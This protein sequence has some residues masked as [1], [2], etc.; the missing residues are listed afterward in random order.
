MAG[1]CALYSLGA[2]LISWLWLAGFFQYY[3]PLTYYL[4]AAYGWFFGEG[5]AVAGV[6]FVYVAAALLATTGMYLFMHRGWGPA[7]ALVSAGAYG[8]T[9]YLVYML[10]H[11]FGRAPETFALGLA[12][13]VFWAFDRLR[14]P[15]AGGIGLA[16]LLL[17]AHLLTHNLTGWFCLAL[18]VAWFVWEAW[19]GEPASAPARGRHLAAGGLSLA[20]ALGL[21]A[22]FW[23]PAIAE[24]AAVQYGEIAGRDFVDYRSQFVALGALLRPVIASDA[25]RLDTV[26]FK[27]GLP[28]WGLALLA[29]ATLGL[30]QAPRRAVLFWLLSAGG[31]LFFI[32]PLSRPVWDAFPA[33]ALVQFPWRLLGPLGFVLAVLAGAGAA[34]WSAWLEHWWPRH[35]S[36]VVGAL[37]VGGCLLAAQPMLHPLPW[38][39]FGPMNMQRLL[40]SEFDWQVGS[41]PTQEFMP[42]AVT[43]PPTAQASLSE[44]YQTGLVDKVNHGA[45]PEGAQVTVLDHG[46]LHDRFAVSSPVGFVLRV[47]TFDFPGWT[48]FVN[49]RRTDITPSQPEGW[50]TLAVPAGAAEVTLR[51]LDTPPRQWGTLLGGLAG[52]ACLALL[53]VETR[54]RGPTPASV[55]LPTKPRAHTPTLGLA[56]LFAAVGGLNILLPSPSTWYATAPAGPVPATRIHAVWQGNLALRGYDLSSLSAQP[57][58]TLSVTLYWQAAAPVSANLRVFVHVLGPDGRLWA[59]SDK[60]HPG[61]F[62]DLPTGRWPVGYAQT[63]EHQVTLAPDAPA[64]LYRVQ[65]GLWQD[66]TGARMHLLDTTGQA[67]SQEAILLTDTLAVQATP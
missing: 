37:A 22:S 5:G 43:V 45:L 23:L 32:L 56:A 47:Y 67:T 14:A 42:A 33:L 15:S 39:D 65:A 11:V 24:R 29:A 34:A 51:L 38:P 26:G 27:L 2:R 10:P 3:A 8:F 25:Y 4:G 46:P 57:G 53:A 35:G 30:A 50:I 54:R 6:K 17:G 44:S 62:Q 28:Q 48:A 52:I 55:T 20:L 59:Q 61:R 9:P 64:G 49:G 16:G 40:G 31:L 21:A 36:T 41:S 13:Y 1:R 19:L 60:F 18:L 63:D 66:Y 58:E 7:P 12:P